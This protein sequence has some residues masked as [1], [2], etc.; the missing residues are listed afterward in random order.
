M[1]LNNPPAAGPRV[2]VSSYTGDDAAS[3]QI[4]TGFPCAAVILMKDNI[5]QITMVKGGQVAHGGATT[6][7]GAPPGTA[8]HATDG[9][10]VSTSNIAVWTT[11]DTNTSPNVY[12]YV[13]IEEL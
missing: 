8:I 9:F 5:H 3:R 7:H 4:S 2:V 6:Y 10:T 13:A 11:Q 1:P 12:Y